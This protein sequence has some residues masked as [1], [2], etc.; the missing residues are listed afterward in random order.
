MKYP[1]FH[2]E[3]GAPSPLRTIVER[4]VRFEEVDV[5]GIVWHGRY[6]SFFEDARVALGERVGLGYMDYYRAGVLTPIKKMHLDYKKPLR[7]RDAFT[8]EAVMH[9]TQA[10]RINMS[11]AIRD[12][13]GQISTTGYTVQLMLDLNGTVMLMQPPC[14]AELYARWARGEIS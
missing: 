7:F 1:Y 11:F 12:A 6:P 9:W 3:P 2:P 8:I 5:M 10:A 14:Q 4:E 13:S